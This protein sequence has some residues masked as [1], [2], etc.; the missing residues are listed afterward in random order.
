MCTNIRHSS[1]AVFSLFNS[2]FGLK[3]KT[4][5]FS[6]NSVCALCLVT[7]LTWLRCFWATNNKNLN[8]KPVWFLQQTEEKNQHDH[9]SPKNIKIQNI[10]A[11]SSISGFCFLFI[12][13]LFLFHFCFS[14]LSHILHY[15]SSKWNCMGA[16]S[17]SSF[18]KTNIQYIRNS[19][20]M[21]FF[22][23]VKSTGCGR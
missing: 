19:K 7:F 12:V 6:H 13:S 23:L 18:L 11:N 10:G 5:S 8:K 1:R 15:D 17:S 2:R 22:G 14:H 4:D 3:R 20:P 21:E 9:N 16:E